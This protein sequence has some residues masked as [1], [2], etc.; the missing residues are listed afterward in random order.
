MGTSLAPD[1]ILKDVSQMWTN[2][3][4]HGL[5]ASAEPGVLRACTLTLVVLVTRDEDPAKIGEILAALMP[6]HPART[7]VIRLAGSAQPSAAVTAQC[8][9]PFGQHRQI[10]CEQIEI[11]SAEDHLDDVVSILGPIAAPDL[12]LVLWCRGNVAIETPSFNRLASL[13]TRVI[14]DSAQWPDP[15]VAIMRLSERARTLRIGDLSWTR[16]TR[17]REMLSQVFENRQYAEHVPEIARVR[18]LYGGARPSVEAYYMAA[19]VTGS[20]ERAGARAELEMDADERT[21]SQELQ[22][23]ELSDHNFTVNLSRLRETLVAAANGVSRCIRLPRAKDHLLMSEE[24]EMVHAD[25]VF[26]RTLA[27]ASRLWA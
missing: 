1:H 17:W 16:L 12:P 27:A 15:K 4:K 24:L 14:V 18:V 22:A 19:W 3:G 5:T 13:A 21:D 2:L 23:V 9:M 7:I 26:E 25:A 11:M 8:W 6:G 20:L 10:C